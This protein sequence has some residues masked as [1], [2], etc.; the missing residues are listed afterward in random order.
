MFY[1][2]FSL[3]FFAVLSVS[4]LFIFRRRPDWQKVRVVSIAFPVVPLAFVLVGAWTIVYGVYYG[5]QNQRGVTIAAVTT[6]AAGAV[7]YH[8]WPRR[9]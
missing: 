3:T 1:I 8:L 9:A 5:L 4:S 6:I 2:G 7:V